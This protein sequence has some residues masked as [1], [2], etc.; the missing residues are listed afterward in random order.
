MLA[1]GLA[2]RT[3]KIKGNIE[4][5]KGRLSN[6]E[7]GTEFV[8]S[9]AAA[10]DAGEQQITDL[11]QDQRQKYDALTREASNCLLASVRQTYNTFPHEALLVT[12]IAPAQST[13]PAQLC[14]ANFRQATVGISW[15][16]ATQ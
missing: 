11:K 15:S 16:N 12:D 14:I 9:L 4:S 6:P 7:P 13:L 8:Q 10:L 2:A 3:N 5:I 1:S